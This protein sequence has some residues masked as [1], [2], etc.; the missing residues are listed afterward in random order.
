MVDYTPVKIQQS[1]YLMHN[2]EKSSL[3]C[4]KK[5]GTSAVRAQNSFSSGKRP[6]SQRFF[7]ASVMGGVGVIRDLSPN[8]PAVLLNCFEL[9]S[10]IKTINRGQYDKSYKTQSYSRKYSLRFTEGYAARGARNVSDMAE[11][12]RCIRT[13]GKSG[14]ELTEVRNHPH[15][16]IN[17]FNNLINGGGVC[18]FPHKGDFYV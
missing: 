16:I 3:T 4:F 5:Y 18:I 6:E 11:I 15:K 8:K 17:H 12:K 9:L 7:C 1:D 14:K 2:S 13:S 10:P